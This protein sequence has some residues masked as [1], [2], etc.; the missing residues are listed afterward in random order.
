[1]K[2]K[3]TVK[4]IHLE[5]FQN[6]NTMLFGIVSQEPDYK[7]SIALNRRMD[8]LLKH[9]E[10]VIVSDKTGNIF[11]FSRF[12]TQAELP[13]DTVYTL[14]S[15]RAG[16]IFLLKKLRNIDYLFFVSRAGHGKEPVISAIL[17]ETEGVGAVFNVDMK[18]LDDKNLSCIYTAGLTE[19]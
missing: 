13:D 12:T 17:R 2:C 9:S 5:P 7:I 18:I 14:I 6:E 11:S 3:H 19:L 4:K 16:A 8:I 1:M 15:N 10:P